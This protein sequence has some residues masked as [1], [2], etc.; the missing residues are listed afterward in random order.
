M[1][2]AGANYAAIRRRSNTL[3]SAAAIGLI[4]DSLRSQ[5]GR[6]RHH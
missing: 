5:H 3:T 2:A 1:P 6:Y 4:I